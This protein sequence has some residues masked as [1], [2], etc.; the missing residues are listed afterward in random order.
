M[1]GHRMVGRPYSTI[2][3]TASILNSSVCRFVLITTSSSAIVYG[4][5][6]STEPRAI[7][8]VVVHH[9]IGRGIC[10]SFM[11]A[12]CRLPTD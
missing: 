6:V 4:C 10:L 3:L 11:P 2:C 8:S 5:E 12:Q 9:A 7:Q 1:P